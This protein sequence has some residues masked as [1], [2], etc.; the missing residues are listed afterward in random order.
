MLNRPQQ[1]TGGNADSQTMAD[2]HE[3]CRHG[4]S[5]PAVRPTKA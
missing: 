4:V 5:A 2:A 1:I 3:V